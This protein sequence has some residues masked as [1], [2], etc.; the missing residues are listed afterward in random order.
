MIHKP[1]KFYQD[2]NIR[3]GKNGRWK[4]ERKKE[5][6]ETRKKENASWSRKTPFS[7]SHNF[8]PNKNFDM[9]SSIKFVGIIEFSSYTKFEHCSF[10]GKP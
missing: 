5:E 3:N 4:K 7:E 8:F 1:A 6:E 9:R 2:R 10:S